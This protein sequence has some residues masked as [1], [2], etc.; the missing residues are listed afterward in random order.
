MSHLEISFRALKV[1]ETSRKLFN[2]H[3]FHGVGV[4]LIIESS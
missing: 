1:L 4:D 3:G 2:A